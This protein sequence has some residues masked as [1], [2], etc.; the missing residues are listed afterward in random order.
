[1]A[2]EYGVQFYTPFIVFALYIAIL[3]LL[4]IASFFRI[5]NDG[6]HFIIYFNLN[7]DIQIKPNKL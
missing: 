4:K 3:A 1:M 2:L 7:F 6:I 5:N